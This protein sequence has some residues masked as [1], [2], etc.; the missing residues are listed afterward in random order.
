MQYLVDLPK[1]TLVDLV[2]LRDQLLSEV[3]ETDN[4][5]LRLLLIYTSMREEIVSMLESSFNQETPSF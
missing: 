5:S 3:L 2:E 1:L 4:D